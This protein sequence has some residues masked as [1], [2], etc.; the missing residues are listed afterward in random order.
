MK[1]GYDVRE[2]M[3]LL[4]TVVFIVIKEISARLASICFHD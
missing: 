2:G 3:I 4:L 1:L